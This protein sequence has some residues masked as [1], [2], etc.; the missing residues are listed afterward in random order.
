M[1]RTALACLLATCTPVPAFAD[2]AAPQFVSEHATCVCPVNGWTAGEDLDDRIAR[3]ERQRDENEVA[4]RL[5]KAER[6][7]RD[8]RRK[9][10]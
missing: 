10:P 6:R 5:A 7:V 2:Q 3:L 1:I 4:L 9:R 8:G